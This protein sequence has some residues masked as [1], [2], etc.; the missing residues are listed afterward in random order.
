MNLTCP[1][2]HLPEIRIVLA[3]ELAVAIRDA[4]PVSPGHSLILP[5]RHV[6][7]FFDTSQE[8]RV[9]MLVLLDAVRG[10]L[11]RE[12]QPDGYN[13]GIN[14]GP[15]AGQTVPHLHLHLIPRYAGDR[16]DPRGGIRWIF[17]EKAQYWS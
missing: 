13:V 7:S 14:D 3:N 5:R 4:Y 2:C 11:E 10:G 8:E 15:A 1:F 12:C 9:A 16:P 6:G 17:P